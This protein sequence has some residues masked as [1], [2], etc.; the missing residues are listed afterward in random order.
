M[1]F[2]L[3]HGPALHDDIYFEVPYM[4]PTSR[5]VMVQEYPGDPTSPGLDYGTANVWRT[6][7]ATG[8][9]DLACEGAIG[10]H[11]CAVSPD[12]TTFYCCRLPREDCVEIIAID[13]ATLEQTAVFFE[14]APT[15]QYSLGSISPD[16]RTFV[17]GAYLGPHHFGIVRFDL[18]TGEW[19][20]I[21]EGA[22]DLCNVHPQLEPRYGRDILVQ[23]NRGARLTDDGEI[24][25]L[26]GEEGATLYLIGTEG[27]GKRTL[28]VGKPFTSPGQGHQCWLGETGEILLTVC[29]DGIAPMPEQG[30]LCRLRPGDAEAVPV[31]RG[32]AFS[33]VGCSR[34]A[35]FF[36]GDAMSP[37]TVVVGSMKT[38]RSHVLCDAECSP[39]P[40]FG[41]HP[42]PY[43]SPDCRWVIFNSDRTGIPQVY[44]AEVPEGLLGEL[45]EE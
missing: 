26:V 8:K 37:W 5:W 44:A 3:T 20:L 34:D 38:G 31:A 39:A 22:D 9:R 21:H 17:T 11:G 15:K 19:R 1:P 28:P 40:A 6:E 16:G 23:H 14:G 24:I 42:H 41:A 32:H 18:R 33:H 25:D 45:D 13:F 7:V 29:G 12:Q 35:R 27:G 2:P 36:C 4:D 30:I 10:I 43:L